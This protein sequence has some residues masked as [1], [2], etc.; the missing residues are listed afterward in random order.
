MVNYL[1][2]RVLVKV[3]SVIIIQLYLSTQ[4]V[5]AAVYLPNPS[6]EIS[7][8]S[9]AQT[10]ETEEVVPSITV[11]GELETQ[12]EL[13]V[14]ETEQAEVENVIAALEDEPVSLKASTL[15]AMGSSVGAAATALIKDNMSAKETSAALIE[16]GYDKTKV[17]N[18]LGNIVA[19]ETKDKQ[20]SQTSA[21][22]DIVDNKTSEIMKPEAF[23]ENNAVS[24]NDKKTTSTEVT[25]TETTEASTSTVEQGASNTQT[26]SALKEQG[27]SATDI[28]KVATDSGKDMKTVAAEMKAAGFSNEDIAKAYIAKAMDWAIDTTAD[29][30]NCA[31]QSLSEVLSGQGNIVSTVELAYDVIVSDIMNTGKVTIEDGQIMSSMSAIQ[32]VASE[33]GVDLAGANGTMTDLENASGSTIVHVDGNHW[34]TV[35]D[36]TGDTVTVMDNGK[37]VTMTKA[38][39]KSRWDGNMLTQNN[40]A[41]G[42][43]LTDQQMVIIK[44][45]DVGGSESEGAG[46]GEPD[47]A[48]S[49]SESNGNQAGEFG[50]SPTNGANSTGGNNG[51]QVG[52]FGSENKGTGTG[53]NSGP[54]VGQEI[55]N[56]TETETAP[57]TVATVGE[58]NN[59]DTDPAKEAKA[60][61]T[62]PE[63][64][65][66]V[67]TEVAPEV[68]TEVAPDPA[69][70]KTATETAQEKSFVDKCIDTV[71]KAVSTVA[72]TVS[73]VGK[74]VA[75][76]VDDALDMVADPI[77]DVGNTITSWG[78][79]LSA[80]GEEKGGIIGGAAKLA[81]AALSGLGNVVEGVGTAVDVAG[82][83][84][85]AEITAFTGIPGLVAGT[86]SVYGLEAETTMALTGTTSH[87]GFVGD[88]D[89]SKQTVVAKLG[90]G[91]MTKDTYDKLSEFAKNADVNVAAVSYDT[92]LPSEDITTASF[93]LT[94]DLAMETDVLGMMDISYG[95]TT[96]IDTKEAALS[97]LTAAQRQALDGMNTVHVSSVP[98]NSNVPEE[99]TLANTLTSY[100]SFGARVDTMNSVRDPAKTTAA[101]A[102][103]TNSFAYSPTDY[104]YTQ[105]NPDIQ[106]NYNNLMSSTNAQAFTGTHAGFMDDSVFADWAMDQFNSNNAEQN[107]NK[108]QDQ[109]H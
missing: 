5:Y 56:N 75:G 79:S 87:L 23:T 86:Q 67:A 17:D 4:I 72:D 70:T 19:S 32:D 93:S 28:L 3:V 53:T 25:Q 43:Q 45:A 78:K 84:I 18:Y 105:T 41:G 109:P 101:V 48:G 108:D 91:Q 82:N 13:S 12:E 88:F 55:G 35:K 106:A 10:K 49:E 83:V 59:V 6:T 34:I 74:A 46:Q 99:G 81:G 64:I 33:H 29:V 15:K 98:G 71:S 102:D 31:V 1:K 80:W 57:E 47:S 69:K 62:A 44:G 76:L 39:L 20:S 22:K 95:S 11:Y 63:T 104:Q 50:G 36:I 2:R 90:I 107:N 68:A 38:E 9:Q 8:L 30:V 58:V 100:T 40:N 92:S 96:T 21:E 16:A 77:K 52:E 97:N 24:T 51:N 60:A 54:G 89:A 27:M 94:A 42:T 26:V 37:E 85:E 7:A 65:T 66:E 103:E 73:N 14:S 61:E